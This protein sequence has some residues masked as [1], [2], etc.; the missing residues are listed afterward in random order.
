MCLLH[1]RTAHM[2]RVA[3]Q[4]ERLGSAVP[5]E[6]ELVKYEIGLAK[7]LYIA[8]RLRRGIEAMHRTTIRLDERL[9][10]TDVLAEAHVDDQGAGPQHS[11]RDAPSAVLRAVV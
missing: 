11:G 2:C 8:D 6:R 1:Q 10:E 7:S 9:G 4:E 5:G 3:R